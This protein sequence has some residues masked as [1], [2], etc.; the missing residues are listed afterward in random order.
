VP[1]K[2]V[3]QELAFAQGI[4]FAA[5]PE[6]LLA[7]RDNGGTWSVFPFAPLR[8][9]VSSVRASRDGQ[10]IWLVSLRGLVFSRDGGQTWSWHDLPFE[11]GGALRLDVAD[12]STLLATA[13][14]GFYIS[15]DSGRTWRQAAAGL[16]AAPPQDVAVTGDVFLVS[17]RTRGL[18]ISYDRGESWSRIEGTLAEGYFPVVTTREAA[19]IVFAASATEGLYAVELS[20]PGTP[21]ASNGPD[22][23]Q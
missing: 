1:L 17:L 12:D 3:V 11:A 18:Y 15:R 22:V 8:L 9:P 14:N 16:P 10:K 5:T 6:G 20:A 4:W 23:K 2:L 7:S 21:A 13:R 19:S